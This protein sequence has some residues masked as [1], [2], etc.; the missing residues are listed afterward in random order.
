MTA[1][2]LKAGV[3][4]LGILGRQYLDFFAKRPDVATVAVCD[5]RQDVADALGAQH[6]A[7]V[8]T[9]Y[10]ALLAEQ[11]PDLVVVATPDHLHKD[12]TLAAIAAGTPLIIQEKPLATALA[13]A[14]EI[15]D[16]VERSSTRLFINYANRAM[17]YDVA[18][19]RVLQDGLIG[20]PVY[21]E[22]RLDDNISVPNALWGGRSRE[23]AAGSSPAHFLLSHVVDLN[24]WWF[25]PQR[26]TDVYA[27][28]QQRVLQFTP[29][30]YDAFLTFDGGLKVRVKAEW[31]KHMDQ[32]VEYYTSIT[33]ASGAVIYNKRPGFGVAESWRANLSAP[34]DFAGLAVRQQQLAARGI[35]TRLSAHSRVDDG[36]YDVSTVTYSFEHVGPDGAHGL[37]LVGPMLDSFAQNTLT[38]SSW[39]GLGPLPTHEDGLRQVQVVQ[40]IL[41]SARRGQPVAL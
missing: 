9:D 16:A 22:S 25:A 11:H 2:E 8:Y 4:G 14:Q 34:L 26:V 3:I 32:I 36:S 21:A 33:G 6:K 19:Y 23:F 5:V 35:P 10:R 24:H 39:Q 41:D 27:I 20:A 12:P 7:T 28:T 30:L 18:T 15:C 37:M 29:D 40:A 13:E 1:R 17:P 38:P 31:I